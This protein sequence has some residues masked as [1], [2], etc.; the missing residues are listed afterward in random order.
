MH[1]HSLLNTDKM[2]VGSNNVIGSSGPPSEGSRSAA[3]TENLSEM[4]FSGT[5]PEPAYQERW[6]WAGNVCSQALQVI[7]THTQV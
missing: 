3:S 7:L 5:T 2:Q 6:E 1:T 4:Q